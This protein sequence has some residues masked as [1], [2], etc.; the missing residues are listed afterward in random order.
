MKRKLCIALLSLCVAV[1]AAGC[2]GKEKSSPSTSSESENKE[3]AALLEG[4][5]LEISDKEIKDYIK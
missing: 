4:K 1:T 5:I 2:G 3:S